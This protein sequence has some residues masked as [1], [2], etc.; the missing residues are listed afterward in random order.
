MQGLVNT[1][2]VKEKAVAFTFDD[3]PNPVYTKEVLDIFRK[4]DGKVTFFM[5]GE[6]MDKHEEVTAEVHSLGHEIANHTFT[7]PDLTKLSQEEARSELQRMEERITRLTGSRPTS[8]R[9]P[10]F[11][12]NDMVLSLADEFG[13]HPIGAA[14]ADS[15]DWEMPGVDYILDKTRP[16]AQQ[17]SIFLFHDG[18]G[19]RSQSM[20]A[21]RILVE[22]LAS[23]GFRFVTLSEL[24]RLA[25]A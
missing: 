25:E 9:P 19:D 11:G 23:E 3:G 10:F 2:P 22:E 6:Q 8:F 17:G 15:R 5:I 20:E 4:V 7:H 1:L 14:N 16:V 24:F 13:Y 18:F 12:V 21:V